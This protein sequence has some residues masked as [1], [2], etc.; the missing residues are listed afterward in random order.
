[1]LPKNFAQ[2]PHSRT[3]GEHRLEVAASNLLV[4]GSDPD[5][6]EAR[7]A[8]NSTHTVWICKREWAGLVRVVIRLRWQ[9][10]RRRTERHNIELILL[11]RSPTDE[12]Q[13]PTRFEAATNVAERRRRISEEHNPEP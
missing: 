4:V 2:R 1:M 5:F 6:H 7:T 3:H 12:R 10:N 8:Q 13:S 9:V 11:Q